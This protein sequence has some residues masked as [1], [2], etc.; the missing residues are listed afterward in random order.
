MLSDQTFVTIGPDG[1]FPLSIDRLPADFFARYL[2]FRGIG[3][4]KKVVGYIPS[5]RRLVLKDEG[6]YVLRPGDEISEEYEAILVRQL[7]NIESQSMLAEETAWAYR[8]GYEDRKS[9][10]YAEVYGGALVDDYEP[11]PD[12]VLPQSDY[13]RG[14]LRGVAVAKVW[15]GGVDVAEQGSW[16]VG[17]SDFK[18]GFQTGYKVQLAKAERPVAD[19]RH[20]EYVRGYQQGHKSGYGPFSACF[21]LTTAKT[22]FDAGWNEGFEV[23]CQERR[24]G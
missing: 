4:A 9:R 10:E 20:P 6:T 13:R 8:K 1:S 21:K 24:N 2:L 14:W 18:R 23:G 19:R 17:S 5:E 15:L 3:E 12:V 22:A 11:M 7:S 16:I